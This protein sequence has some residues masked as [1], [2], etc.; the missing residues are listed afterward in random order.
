MNFKF[1]K[2]KTVLEILNQ[3]TCLMT[4]DEKIEYLKVIIPQVCPG[5]NV[6]KNPKK[7]ESRVLDLLPGRAEL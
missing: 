6:S 1:W 7:K 4:H 5:V 3:Q 2:K